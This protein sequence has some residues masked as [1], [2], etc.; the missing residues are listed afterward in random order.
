MQ[1]EHLNL[2]VSNIDAE[3]VFYEAAFPHWHVRGS[4][5]SDWFGKPRQWLHFGDDDQ[6]LTFNDNGVGENRD[7]ADHQVGL[8]HFAFVTSDIAGVQKR[9]A[10]AGFDIAKDGAGDPYRTNFYY[11]DPA[12]YE[13]E[14]VE[15]HSD[16][17]AERNRYVV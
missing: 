5:E 12:G 13:V 4:G 17:P 2:V 14:F 3:L 7:L 16:Q 15:Y 6:Y 9:L 1:L 11:I 8:A 10:E